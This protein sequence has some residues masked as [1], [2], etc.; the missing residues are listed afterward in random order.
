MCSGDAPRKKAPKAIVAAT[1]L[2]P[3]WTFAFLLMFLPPSEYSTH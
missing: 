2:A 1:L 3:A